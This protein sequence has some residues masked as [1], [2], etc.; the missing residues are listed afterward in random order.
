[1]HPGRPPQM[2]AANTPHVFV[3]YS[4]ESEA[5]KRWVRSLAEDLTKKGV[6]TTLDQWN[7]RVGDD[8]GKFM[9][10]SIETATHIVLV[11]TEA[12]SRMANDREGGV[13]YEQAVFVG[14]LLMSRVQ[15]NSR[16][17]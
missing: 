9:E 13:G 15:L 6:K 7:L 2:T 16:F 3:S 10:S 5:H 4:H 1:M 8:I 11:C 14:E 12:S 17:L